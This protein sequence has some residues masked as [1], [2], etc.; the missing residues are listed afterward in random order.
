MAATE[1]PGLLEGKNI[2]VMG[3]I[4][5]DSFAWVI[6]EK[7]AE[8]G[9]EVTYS[10]VNDR[11]VMM[12]RR[13]FRNAQVELGDR[14]ILECDVTSD[15]SIKNFSEGLESQIDGLVYSIAFANPQTAMGRPSYKTPRADIHQALD[16]SSVGFQMVVGG[17]LEAN[18]FNP[19]SS[20]VAMTFDS[21]RVYPNYGWMTPAKAT[22]EAEV[23]LLGA[24][25]AH[26]GI[27]VYALSSGPQTTMAA[28]RIPGFNDIGDVWAERA[29]LG[30]DLRE[31]RYS[32]A[33]HAAFF[34]SDYSEGAT[35]NVH[36]VDGGFNSV[37]MP[38]SPYIEQTPAENPP[39]I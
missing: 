29:P 34:L 26:R 8:E 12:A 2:L 16:I 18:K 21:Q 28:S 39:E 31:G 9:V 13:N 32:V 3:L 37:A 27:R 22:L 23:K 36:F 33:K 19:S 38:F 35:G 7:A 15:E 24:E 10:A 25:L 20:I 14:R 1:R 30:W 4:S 17:L 11:F 5:P 6:G